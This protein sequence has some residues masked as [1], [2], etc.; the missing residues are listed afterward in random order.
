MMMTPNRIESKNNCQRLRERRQTSRRRRN[1]VWRLSFCLA[2]ALCLGLALQ[3]SGLALLIVDPQDPVFGPAFH[4]PFDPSNA[5][6]GATSFTITRAGVE[7]TFSTTNPNGL[8]FCSG[9]NC[10]LRAPRVGGIHINIS[11]G[12]SAIGF[13]HRWVECP[14]RAVFHGSLGSET[15]TFPLNTRS[16]FI[17]ASNIGDI[18]LVTLESQCGPAESW[19]DM[20]FVPAPPP[21]PSPTPTPTVRYADL[22][23]TQTGSGLASNNQHGAF[24]VDVANLGPDAATDLRVL[25]FLPNGMTLTGIS[26]AGT[27]NGNVATIHLA[28]LPPNFG[29]RIAT[30]NFDTLPFPAFGCGHKLLNVAVA[31]SSSIETNFTNNLSWGLTTYDN[32]ARRGSFGEI[33]DNGIDDNC[34]GLADC[35]DPGCGCF[36]PAWQTG[37]HLQ[38]NGAVQILPISSPIPSTGGMFVTC[39]PQNNPAHTQRCAVQN[40]LTGTFLNIP[41]FC[42]EQPSLGDPNDTERRRVQCPAPHDPNFKQ[43]DP[44]T[45]VYGFGYT[46]AGRMMT[47]TIHYENRHGSR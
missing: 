32:E 44:E 14:G 17:G 1:V 42:C 29:S 40:P 19:D 5:P 27:V 18:F 36:Q 23:A 2:A 10:Q 24:D 33:C 35:S 22:V 4:E 12:V 11:P 20:L 30:L 8:F 37:A 34:D 7:F 13:Q 41:A 6:Q 9:N 39:G 46:E 31:T 15:F 43:S 38:C 16:G 26:P 25:D 45:N 28:D 21:P 3:S 47:Y